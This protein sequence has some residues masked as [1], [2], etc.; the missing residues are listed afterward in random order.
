MG[1]LSPEGCRSAYYVLTAKAGLTATIELIW[2]FIDRPPD[3]ASEGRV[4]EAPGRPES[5]VLTEIR[6][7]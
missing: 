2:Y 4:L 7:F 1:S 5:V 3:D 6:S